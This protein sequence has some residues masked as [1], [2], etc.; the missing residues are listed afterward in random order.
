MPLPFPL[1]RTVPVK[2]S[3]ASEMLTIVSTHIA[4]TVFSVPTEV[5]KP[6]QASAT[7][8]PTWRF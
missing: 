6:I 8:T 1:I 5:R 3:R 2:A 7:S 4:A